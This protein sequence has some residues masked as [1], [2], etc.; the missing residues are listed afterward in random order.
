MTKMNKDFEVGKFYI[1]HVSPF[2]MRSVAALC[3]RVLKRKIDFQYLS[4]NEKGEFS[5]VKISRSLTKA[6]EHRHACAYVSDPWSGIASTFA[7]MEANK[8][9]MW[10]T[11]T[12]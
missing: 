4:R 12:S 2:S 3:T 10:D 9:S 11:A 6:S 7:N 5:K 1:L 8:P